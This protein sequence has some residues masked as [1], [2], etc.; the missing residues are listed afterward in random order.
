[1]NP[2]FKA[3]PWPLHLTEGRSGSGRSQLMQQPES[4]KGA[5]QRHTVVG[6]ISDEGREAKSRIIKHRCQTLNRHEQMLLGLRV[7]T[8][9]VPILPRST[10]RLSQDG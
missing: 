4:I 2:G 7:F 1:M 5:S 6:F 8:M 9:T 3:L 10:P